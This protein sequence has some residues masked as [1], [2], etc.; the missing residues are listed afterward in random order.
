METEKI[1]ILLEAYRSNYP[2]SIQPNRLNLEISPEDLK[3][4]NQDLLDYGLIETT[5]EDFGDFDKYKISME[6]LSA[7]KIG[8]EEYF[9]LN[10]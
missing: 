3:S 7:L 2:K 5:K 1:E 6:G 4:I 10:Y 9:Y 8:V